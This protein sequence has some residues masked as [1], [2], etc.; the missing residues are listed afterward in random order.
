MHGEDKHG[1]KMT[2]PRDWTNSIALKYSAFRWSVIR[3]TKPQIKIIS[4]ANH[5]KVEFHK[6]PIRACA[7]THTS[8]TACNAGKRQ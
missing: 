5:N 8:K 4:T 7:Q 3:K 2:N 6:E 1:F